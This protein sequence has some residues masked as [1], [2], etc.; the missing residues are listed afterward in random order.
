MCVSDY[1]GMKTK[2]EREKNG[3]QFGVKAR[4]CNFYSKRKRLVK[5]NDNARRYLYA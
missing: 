1:G 3:Y 2:I 5:L 4:R